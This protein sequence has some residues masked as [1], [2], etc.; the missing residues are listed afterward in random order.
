[1]AINDGSKDISYSPS[2]MLLVRQLDNLS[3][4]ES[5]YSAMAQF[6]GVH[7]VI[8]I[9]DKL[10]KMSCEFTFIEFVNVQVSG[11]TFVYVI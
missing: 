7:R 10:T 11:G 1:M 2:N 8:L 4:E 6:Q 5:V 3:S 9:R